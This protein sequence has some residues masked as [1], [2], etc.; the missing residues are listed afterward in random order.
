MTYDGGNLSWL[1]T[2]TKMFLLI[3]Q[4]FNTS[5]FGRHVADWLVENMTLD[6]TLSLDVSV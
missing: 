5:R 2:D 6:M 1:G 3:K 4:L